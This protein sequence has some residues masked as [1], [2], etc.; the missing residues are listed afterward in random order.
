M[1]ILAFINDYYGDAVEVEVNFKRTLGLFDEKLYGVG[2]AHSR[3]NNFFHVDED[4]NFYD[5]N[6]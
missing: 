6:Y 3:P 1:R 5:T 2:C 4:L